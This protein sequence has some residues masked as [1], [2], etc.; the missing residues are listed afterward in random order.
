LAFYYGGIT[1]QYIRR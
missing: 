1:L